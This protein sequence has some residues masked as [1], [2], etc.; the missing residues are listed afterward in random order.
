MTKQTK[1][2]I[3]QETT[4]V[5]QKKRRLDKNCDYKHVWNTRRF[6]KIIKDFWNDVDAFYENEGGAYNNDDDVDQQYI[7]AI[8][9]LKK[10]AA[11]KA[12]IFIIYIYFGKNPHKTARALKTTPNAI[13]RIESVIRKEIKE[14]IC[15]L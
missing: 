4:E 14:V 13:C 8:T 12:N 6:R 15:T 1:S 2:E 3:L 5:K 7:K 9:A 10:I 11:W